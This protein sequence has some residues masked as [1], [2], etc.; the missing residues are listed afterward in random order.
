METSTG[1]ILRK[2][3]TA[4]G[5]NLHPSSFRAQVR[6]LVKV[7]I[8]ILA[9]DFTAA[10]E[11]DRSKVSEFTKMPPSE[12][13][14]GLSR[15]TLPAHDTFSLASYRK[16]TVPIDRVYSLMG[17]LGVK[18]LA[19]HAEGPTK[20]L[21]W[22]LDEVV[23]TTNDVSIFNW[24]GKDLGIPIR[25]RS[26]YPSSLTA[27]SPEKKGT[28]FTTINGELAV[29]SKEKRHILQDTASKITLLLLQS[30]N[31]IKKTA[32]PDTPTNLLQTILNFI[33]KVGFKNL[34]PQLLHLGKLMVY[35]ENT[36]G[37]EKYKPKIGYKIEEEK[38]KRVLI[39][40]EK[41]KTQNNGNIT[42]R[43]GFKRPQKPQIP[44]MA[45]MPQMPHISAPKLSLGLGGFGKKTRESQ[46]PMKESVD[47]SPVL[48][49]DP[50]L[51]V[52]DSQT[53]EEPKSLIDEVNHLKI[54]ISKTFLNNFNHSLM[55]SKLLN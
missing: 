54:K 16:Y 12:C 27:F 33:K 11:A 35:L 46:P 43:F 34:R 31:F 13:C 2:L 17:V 39:R 52:R 3:F 45:Q 18:F 36:Q 30:I 51:S 23:I 7:L 37:L 14:H 28:Y 26:L 1:Q 5:F 15:P 32:H 55:R 25:G 6:T 9:D 50:E 8:M 41:P 42:S 44:H 24:A 21:C 49:V 22:L 40:E 10:I 53:E 38:A 20:A 47:T 4:L 29:A 19:F 48:H